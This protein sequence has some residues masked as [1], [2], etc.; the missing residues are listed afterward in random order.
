MTKINNPDETG[1]SFDD[2]MWK[3]FPCPNP[4]G[5]WRECPPL[6]ANLEDAKGAREWMLHTS[7]GE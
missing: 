1:S 7:Y 5:S 2:A 3:A 6:E 4:P